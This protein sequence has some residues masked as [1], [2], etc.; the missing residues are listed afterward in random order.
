MT[1]NDLLAIIRTIK[2]Y[3]SPPQVEG[4]AYFEREP[5]QKFGSVSSGICMKWC[6]FRDD[7][8]LEKATEEDIL[9]ADWEMRKSKNLKKISFNQ[10]EPHIEQC[11]SCLKADWK[12]ENKN[13]KFYELRIGS[14]QMILCEDCARD[15]A[16]II[17]N[18]IK[19]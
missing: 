9:K 14:M 11:N 19:D 17:T 6:W 12:A 15:L 10:I 7:V 13:L 3:S 1:R 2:S 18:I 16:G 5:W 8:I 4:D